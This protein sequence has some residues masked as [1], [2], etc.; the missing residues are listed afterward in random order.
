MTRGIRIPTY[1]Y[2]YLILESDISDLVEMQ[3][4]YRTNAILP[5]PDDSK[6]I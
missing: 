3:A 1:L 5:Y 4:F 2:L 6:F